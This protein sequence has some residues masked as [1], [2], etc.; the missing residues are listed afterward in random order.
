MFPFTRQQFIDQTLTYEGTPYQHQGR[1]KGVAID[2]IGLVVCPM[3]DLG[4]DL[5][6]LPKAYSSRP[7]KD[8]LLTHLSDSP[9]IYQV[10]DDEILPG[11]V[12]AL[13]IGGALSHFAIYLGENRMIHSYYK[14][15]VLRADFTVWK[16]SLISV[17]RPKF[18][19][20][21]L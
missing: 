11:D 17:W 14:Q 7:S 16:P 21:T 2:C 15:S 1:K 5:S 18:Y 19:G 13:C 9:D 8:L 4:A 20:E 6:Y 3:Q 12:L 10:A